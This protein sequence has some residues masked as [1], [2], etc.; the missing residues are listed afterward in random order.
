MVPQWWNLRELG[1]CGTNSCPL[2][3]FLSP[4]RAWWPQLSL[5]RFL[6]L[7]RYAYASNFHPKWGE[8]KTRATSH[9][10]SC[11]FYTKNYLQYVSLSL[12]HTH[13]RPR[14]RNSAVYHLWPQC[15]FSYPWVRKEIG[16]KFLTQMARDGMDDAYHISSGAAGGYSIS[17]PSLGDSSKTTKASRSF[18][19][20][21]VS[22]FRHNPRTWDFKIRSKNR[23]RK[24]EGTRKDQ[25][26]LREAEAASTGGFVGELGWKSEPAVPNLSSTCRGPILRCQSHLEHY[27]NSKA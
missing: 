2:S 14:I 5:V 26:A 9:L 18:W 23:C 12:S 16:S 19:A 17:G 15:W 1:T 21:C 20:V 6:S 27:A 11:P 22:P 25:Q 7:L 24:V 4:L 13:T 8:R 3:L 10:A